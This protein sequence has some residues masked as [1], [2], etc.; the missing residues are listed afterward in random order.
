MTNIYKNAQRIMGLLED[1]NEIYS[2]V[3]ASNIHYVTDKV[4]IVKIQ[5]PETGKLRLAVIVDSN[6][7]IS[8]IVKANNEITLIQKQLIE[9]QGDDLVLFL[10]Y[11]LR[12]YLE[13]RYS[14]LVVDDQLPK[15]LPYK[16]IRRHPTISELVEDIN[17]NA[18]VYA[19]C[20][21]KTSQ[22][23]QS[24]GRH[25]FKSLLRL[26]NYG[27]SSSIDELLQESIQNINDGDCPFDIPSV[28]F[29]YDK[30]SNKM[31]AVISKFGK[32]TRI[33]DSW[34]LVLNLDHQFLI[35]SHWTEATELLKESFPETYQQY[36]PRLNAR[37]TEM[38]TIA[39]K[40][41]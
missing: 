28:P 31:D 12:L 23:H 25:L 1:D 8:H 33:P 32:Q 16:L 30:V 35:W 2:R 38:L 26:F 3:W 27:E 13:D 34:E 7:K 21:S 36:E 19:V 10:D 11:L 37:L 6:T 39:S 4:G 5:D 18:L 24:F 41:A 29:Y 9:S 14:L 40:S 15:E 17:F 22:P 20:A